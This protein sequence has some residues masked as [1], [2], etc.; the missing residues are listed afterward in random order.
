VQRVHQRFFCLRFDHMVVIP[1]N[2]IGLTSK[3]QR[4]RPKMVCFPK[5]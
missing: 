4:L 2:I 5:S 3:K 1:M